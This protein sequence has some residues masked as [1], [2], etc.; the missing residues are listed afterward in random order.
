MNFLYKF[1]KVFFY[2]SASVLL[3]DIVILIVLFP[4]VNGIGA[5]GLIVIPFIA[6]GIISF[7]VFLISSIAIARKHRT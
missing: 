6:I 3:V 2:F 1:F 7:L 4:K 5:G